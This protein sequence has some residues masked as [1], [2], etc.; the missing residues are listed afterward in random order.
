[1]VTIYDVDATQLINKA[2]EALKSKIKEPDYTKFVKTGAGR[3]RPPIEIDWF[4]KRSA[5]ILR[6]VYMLGPIGTNKMRVHF[7]NNKNRGHQPSHFYE[8]GG[9]ITR[10]ALQELTKAGLIIDTNKKGH[11]G[12]VVT[13]QGKSFLDGLAKQLVKK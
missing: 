2:A 7:G 5:A 1:M 4:F 3:E 8:A 11:K 13:N 10:N 6:K 12:K 9:K